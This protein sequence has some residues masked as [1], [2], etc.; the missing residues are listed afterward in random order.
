M[1]ASAS[2]ILTTQKN[3]VVAI[4]AVAGFLQTLYNNIPTAQLAQSAATTSASKLY[5]ASTK[6]ASH[7]NTICVCN[8]AGSAATFS[9]FIVPSSGTAGAGNAIFYSSAIAANTTFTSNVIFIIP[10][11]GTLWA[12]ASATTVTFNIAGGASI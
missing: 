8:T 1:T 3:N 12:S 6:I 5:T 9:I 4:N 11:G 10:A 7:I 2:D